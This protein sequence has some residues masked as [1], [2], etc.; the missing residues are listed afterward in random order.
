ME[1]GLL[2]IS[3]GELPDQE[4]EE[5]EGQLDESLSDIR[6]FFLKKLFILGGLELGCNHIMH[7]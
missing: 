6:Y 7:S 3:D 1:N 4:D 2:S 5:E